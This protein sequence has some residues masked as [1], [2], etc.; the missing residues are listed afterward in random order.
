MQLRTKRSIYDFLAKLCVMWGTVA[1]VGGN[2]AYKKN[3]VVRVATFWHDSMYTSGKFIQFL[4]NIL[5][6]RIFLWK[7][8]KHNCLCAYKGHHLVWLIMSSLIF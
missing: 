5:K 6:K 7:F 8:I 2:D 1:V 4:N 3:R